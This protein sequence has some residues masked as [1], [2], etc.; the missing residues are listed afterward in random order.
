MVPKVVLSR[1]PLGSLLFGFQ[2]PACIARVMGPAPRWQMEAVVDEQLKVVLPSVTLPA[3]TPA[4]MHAHA[5]GFSIDF[6]L[7]AVRSALHLRESHQADERW[8]KTHLPCCCTNLMLY[9]PADM[10]EGMPDWGPMCDITPSY[11]WSENKL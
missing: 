8:V 6:S 7:P 4:L 2:V 10:L 11:T 5:H 1:L 9:I 3:Y